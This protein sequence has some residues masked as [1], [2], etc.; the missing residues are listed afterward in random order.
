LRR[1]PGLFSAA[2]A[3]AAI[4]C[5]SGDT[6]TPVRREKTAPVRLFVDATDKA[7]LDF[8]HDNG[9]TDRKY[10]PEIMGS[11][12]S[13][14]DYDGDGLFDLYLVQSG[15]VPGTDD[16]APRPG[17]RLFRN[18]GDGTFADVTQRTGVGDS[19][20][21]MGSV[22]ADYDNDGDTDLYVVNYGADVLLRNDG[23]GSFSDVTGEAGIKSP[24]WGSSASFFDSDRDGDLDLYVTNYLDFDLD[25]HVDCG[26][27]SRGFVSYC[28]P[29]VYES[30]PDVFFRNLG[31]GTFEE[32]TKAAGF[33][34]TTGKGLGVVA[35]DLTND[36]WPDLYIANDAT[37]NFLFRN[38]KDGTF[39]EAALWLGVGHNEDGTTEA[40]MGT[41]AGDVN[42][43]GWLDLLVTNLSAESNALYLGGD[44]FFTYN[45]RAAGLYGPSYLYV[46]FGNH[47]QDLDNDADLD[48]LVTNG[49]VIDNIELLDDSQS[50]RQPTQVFWNDGSGHFEEVE[51]ALIQ[52]L[53][54]PR[55]GRGTMTL[56]LG[57]DG[58]L[59]AVVSYNND[60]T[61]LFQNTWTGDG[62]WIGF[63]TGA[64]NSRIEVETASGRQLKEVVL[65]SSYQTSSEP[66]LHFGLG[67]FQAAPKVVVAS[68]VIPGRRRYLGLPAGRYYRLSSSDLAP[69]VAADQ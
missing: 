59:D 41:S 23:D 63:V 20:Y 67:S 19:G 28:S 32:T 7:R 35:T 55:V 52:D 17:N 16:T 50:F 9:S 51:P 6:E 53:A 68:S 46:G 27:P 42:A 15:P 30:V 14:I 61:R 37:P 12:G 10:L 39:E 54:V 36:G 66:S 26:S 2:I 25:K 45:A 44:V 1:A 29:D 5:G 11:G 21:G 18:L 33:I 22:A 58:R 64:A 57:A 47:L 69:G 38:L 43:D 31:D 34:D 40:G 65:G 56:D 3:L 8:V 62:N 48:L 24:L 4:A 13:V 60:R 49:H